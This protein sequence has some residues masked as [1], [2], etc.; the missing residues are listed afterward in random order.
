MGRQGGDSIE[1]RIINFKR[2]RTIKQR[3]QRKI[4]N[5]KKHEEYQSVK[6]KTRKKKD[7]QESARETQTGKQNRK[8]TKEK[9]TR[10]EERKMTT[11]KRRKLLVK[12]TF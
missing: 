7:K 1:A 10:E 6:I 8:S 2:D 4:Q 12:T 9:N 11:N 3:I 5:T